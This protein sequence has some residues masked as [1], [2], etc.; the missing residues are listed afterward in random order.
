M[1][2]SAS[3]NTTQTLEDL[4]R[5][6]SSTNYDKVLGESLQEIERPQKEGNRTPS[7]YPSESPDMNEENVEVESPSLCSEKQPLRLKLNMT[8]DDYEGGTADPQGPTDRGVMPTL[9]G[10]ITDSLGNESEIG[11][12]VPPKMLSPTKEVA[13]PTKEEPAE[14]LPT[15][16]EEEEPSM[17]RSNEEEEYDESF[18][19]E[20]N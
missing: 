12:A 20:S 6:G 5:Q 16:E 2:F 13:S 1:D 4:K 10:I 11:D 9:S 19:K 17:L 7:K 18:E 3:C 14:P 15:K 8:V